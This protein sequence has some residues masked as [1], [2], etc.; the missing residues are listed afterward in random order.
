ML[1]ELPPIEYV[2]AS[3]VSEA[4]RYLLQYG[5]RAKVLG[6]GTDLLG[7]MKDRVVGPKMPLPEVLIDIK[8]IQ[9]MDIIEYKKG[10]GLRIGAAA[11][12]RSIETSNVVLE[13]FP[14]LAQASNSVATMQIRN[15]GTLGGNLCQRPWCWYFR[16][17][18]FDCYKKGGKQCYAITGNNKYYFS[19]LGLGICVM[20]HPSDTAPALIALGASVKIESTRGSRTMPLTE[21]FNGPRE[22]FETVLND[23]EILTE[24]FVPD[25]P[26][27]TFG[28]YLKERLRGTWDFAL[29]SVAVV[30]RVNDGICHN[31]SIILGGVAPIPWR[32]DAAEK[33]LRGNPIGDDTA[34]KAAN[35]AMEGARPL[36]LN[37][38]KIPMTKA[39]VKR[40][41]I[42]CFA[43]YSK[44]VQ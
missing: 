10:K 27:G 5:P 3:T 25:Q 1:Y 34:E 24:V 8:G 37:R 36:S 6:G 16:L 41:V 35:T 7:L 12:L 4:T 43:Q 2:K 29:S 44:Q 40:A 39:L 31:A 28:T 30:T 18:N 38:Y 13:S 15:M 22:T 33:A 23:D 26:K 14:I 20:A 11:T 17:S 21:F 19:V 9:G 32:A 42:S